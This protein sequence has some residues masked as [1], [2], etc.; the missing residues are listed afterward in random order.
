M[1][2]PN[3]IPD[4]KQRLERIAALLADWPRQGSR[5]R[6]NRERLA[7]PAIQR[8][9]A[10][11]GRGYP[12]TATFEEVQCHDLSSRGF[13]FLYP[14]PPSFTLLIAL[15]SGVGTETLHMVAKVC[16]CREGFWNRERQ[17]LVG[18]RFV[19]RITGAYQSGPPIPLAG[20]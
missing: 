14:T 6:R 12:P 1:S 2:Q 9:A 10:C 8:I 20:R 18:C 17:F 7:F 16:H 13:S 3:P 5:E 4:H 19:G 11:D 15:L